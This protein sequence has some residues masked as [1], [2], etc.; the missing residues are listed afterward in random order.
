MKTNKKIKSEYIIEVSDPK[1]GM[2]G[3]LV[4]D[5]TVLGPGKGGIR[6]TPDITTEEVCRL[7]QTMTLKNALADIPFGGAKGGIRWPGGS[8]ELKKEFVQSYARAISPFIPAKYIAGPDVNTGEKEMSWLVEATGLWHAATGKPENLCVEVPGNCKGGL[9][10]KCG[11]PHEA[12]STGFGVAQA[13]RIAAEVMGINIKGAEISIHGFGN[14]GTFAY[15]FL[16]KMGAKITA[17]ADKDSVIYSKDGFDKN[18][19]GKLIKEKKAVSHY[20]GNVKKLKAEEF[21]KIPVDI[22]I[23]ASVT[24]VINDTNKKHIKAKIIV[25][26]ANIPMRENIEDEF[27][28]KGVLIVPDF[29][30]NSGGVI[31]SFCEHEGH[32]LDLMF[33]TVENKIT[34][35]ARIVLEESIRKNKN[36]RHVA[37]E[38][39]QSRLHFGKTQKEDKLVCINC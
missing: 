30:A 3:I 22:L 18:Q 24:D 25:E 20:R 10:K 12:G 4:I 37:L 8:E 19:I 29:V 32:T 15:R 7:A 16:T 6:M 5:N 28:Q 11:I 38:L 14:V 13:T 21:W 9:C 27:L 36:P 33:K 2:E 23:P 17:I 39:A 35:T 31:S 1:I 26:A 34:N